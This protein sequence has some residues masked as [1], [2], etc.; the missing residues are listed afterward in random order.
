MSNVHRKQSKPTDKDLRETPG[1]GTSR[2]T[3][4]KGDLD[5]NDGENS[6]EGDVENDVTSAGGIDPD[7]RGRANK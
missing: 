2:G 1:I 7:Q 3:I 5:V 4:R 6:F